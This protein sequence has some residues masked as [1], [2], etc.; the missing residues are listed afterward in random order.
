LIIAARPTAFPKDKLIFGPKQIIG[1][2]NQDPEISQQISLWSQGGS[3]VIQGSLLVIPLE[4]S[5]LY[6][7]PLY[8]KAEAGK[9]PE[10]KRVVVAYENKIAMEE[11]LE[12]GLVRIFGGA[13]PAGRQGTGARPQGTATVRPQV[14]PAQDIQERIQ[15]A[16]G[17]YEEALR[18][19][20]D[21]D[22]ARYG[23]AIRRLG[24][25]LKQ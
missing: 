19:Q 1:R 12:E 13:L 21:G 24:D 3:Q 15:R 7:R 9:I 10:L 20:R 25:I 14:A 8:L 4:E 22:W 5:L 11:T 18:A 2:I 6:V 16:L 23:E 17:A